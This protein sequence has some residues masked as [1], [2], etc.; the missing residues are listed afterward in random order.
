M[1]SSMHDAM[2]DAYHRPSPDQVGSRSQQFARC[3]D[4]IKSIRGPVMLGDDT[5]IAV[6]NRQTRRYANFLDLASEQDVGLTGGL[7]ERKFDA[8]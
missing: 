3:R 5:A 8:G 4:M 1:H 6:L 7:V 2:S